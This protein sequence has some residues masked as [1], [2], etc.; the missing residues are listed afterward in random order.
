VFSELV[1]AATIA[2]AR[3]V[4]DPSRPMTMKKQLDRHLLAAWLNFANG[5]IDLN[6]PVDTD[7]DGANDA[8][9][10]ATVVAAEIARL[11]PAT[12]NAQLESH[13]NK[14]ERINLRDG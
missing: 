9:F 3:D 12:T 2:R 5:G 11:D 4:L 7:G 13:K 6:D 10:A 14:L 1:D 8:T